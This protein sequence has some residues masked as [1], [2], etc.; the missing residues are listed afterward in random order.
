MKDDVI[1]SISI[2]GNCGNG[3]TTYETKSNGKF[4]RKIIDNM[5]KQI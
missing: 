5:T 4:T 2:I 1:Y 3:E